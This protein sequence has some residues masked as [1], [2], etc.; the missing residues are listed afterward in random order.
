MDASL[1]ILMVEDNHSDIRLAHEYLK[2]NRSLATMNV[3]RDGA[4]LLAYLRRQGQQAQPQQPDVILFSLANLL[5][6]GCNIL[7][8]IKQ[9]ST[10]KQIPIVVLTA[11]EGE[12]EVLLPDRS[13]VD[14]CLAKP[15]RMEH[16]TTIVR[17]LNPSVS[18]N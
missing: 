6:G 18:V 1:D 17:H 15:L 16:I 14:L 7:A 2:A 5:D 12:E 3:V 4:E 8:E 11:F 9:D 10:L 13:H